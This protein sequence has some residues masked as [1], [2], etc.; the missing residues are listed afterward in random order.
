[1]SDSDNDFIDDDELP[2]RGSRAKKR[3]RAAWEASIHERENPLIGEQTGVGLIEELAWKAEA[4]KRERIRQDTQPF[5]R[6]IIRHVVL[7]IDLSEA[8]AEKDMR[9]NRFVVT[10]NYAK[11]YVR[12]FFEQNPISQM[13]V[14][15]MHD[16]LAVRLSELSGNPNDHINAIQELR[17]GRSP[18][19]PKGSPSLENALK[20]AKATLFHTPKHGTREVIIIMAALLTVDPGDIH[21]TIKACVKE[22]LRVSII[23][24]SARLKICVEICN[25][26]N[27]GDESVYGVALD[28]QHF[29]ELLMATTTPPVIRRAEE[30]EANK[31]SLLMMGFP[32]RV[33]EDAPSLC[34]CHGEM[35]R[36]GYICSRCEAK[37]CTLPQQCPSCKMTLILSTHLARSYHHLFPLRS[38][39]AVD[40]KRLRSQKV[41]TTQCRGCQSNF[42]PLPLEEKNRSEEVTEINPHK[43]VEREEG[44]AESARYECQACAS[45][46]CIDCDMFCHEVVHNCPGCSSGVKAVVDGSAGD[47]MDVD[48]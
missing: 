44:P 14:L 33:E 18:K 1:M 13:C 29:K 46:F 22:R 15:G 9:P 25:K 43:R 7:V 34:A 6:G 41:K 31:A 28:Q 16:G 8:M 39:I 40:W 37:V 17:T 48:S 10:I 19:E 47:K 20:M 5:Q 30:M 11:E 4:K 26:T 3:T 35:H 36:G 12:E 23:G 27:A 21:V 24:M 2:T 38:W 42:P 32:S 45:H